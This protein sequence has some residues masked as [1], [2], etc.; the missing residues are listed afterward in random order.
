MKIFKVTKGLFLSKYT[1]KQLGETLQTGLLFEAFS[2][3]DYGLDDI[4]WSNHNISIYLSGQNISHA[5]TDF[6][7]L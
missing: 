2:G 4:E 1:K 7:L 5:N 6:T 3:F